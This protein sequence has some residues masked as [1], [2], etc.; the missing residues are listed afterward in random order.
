[1]PIGEGISSTASKVWN[2]GLVPAWEMVS[3]FFAHDIPDFFVNTIYKEG[4][5]PAWDWLKGD[6]WYQIITKKFFLYLLFVH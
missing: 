3:N 1:M 2:E 5:K 4:L 6:K